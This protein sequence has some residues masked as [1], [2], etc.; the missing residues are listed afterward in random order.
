MNSETLDLL[1]VLGQFLNNNPKA[2][3]QN[4]VNKVMKTGVD[5]K[6][7]LKALVKEYLEY[8]D[9]LER[10]YDDILKE[11]EPLDYINNEYY[12]NINVSGKKFSGWEIK[13][14][15]YAPYELFVYDDFY[16]MD[17]VILPRVGYFKKPFP[18]LGVYQNGR[19][20][21][22]IT[23]N[24]INTM[25]EPINK[26]HGKVLTFGLGLGYFAYMASNK[27]DVESV[28]IVEADPKIIN[29]FKSIILPNFKNKD[30]INIIEADAYSYLKK[31]KDNEYDYIF[32]DIYHDASDGLDTYMKMRKNV[33]K[34]NN[35]EVEFWIYNTIKYY[36]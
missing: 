16:D 5:E 3:T 12:K 30:K 24:E 22:S 25:K 26:A 18:Y 23:P 1:T 33:D 9:L 6:A 15:K 8:N 17:G 13:M 35:T 21:M 32:V 19:L 10:Y 31:L 27:S 34:L 29:L 4:Q 11:L 36:L 7:A 2:V 14:D 20:W 28:T